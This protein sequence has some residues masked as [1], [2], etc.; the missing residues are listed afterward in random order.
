MSIFATIIIAIVCF[1][2]GS[3]S[4]L[5]IAIL[6]VRSK[7]KDAIANGIIEIDGRTFLLGEL[8]EKRSD[9]K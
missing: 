2:I 8:I 1:F 9:L 4:G 5:G 6:G 7:Q 3:A